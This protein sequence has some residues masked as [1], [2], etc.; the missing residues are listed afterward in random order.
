MNYKVLF[1]SALFITWTSYLSAQGINELDLELNK[2]APDCINAKKLLIAT[3]SDSTRLQSYVSSITESLANLEALQQNLDAGCD[4]LLASYKQGSFLETASS[5]FSTINTLQEKLKASL[6]HSGL[7]IDM[8]KKFSIMMEMLNEISAD[9]MQTTTDS[10]SLMCDEGRAKVLAFSQNINDVLMSIKQNYLE[11]FIPNR[12]ETINK[13]LEKCP[14]TQ[15]GLITKTYLNTGNEFEKRIPRARFEDYKITFDKPFAEV[16]S[17]AVSLAG[18]DMDTELPAVVALVQK[19]TETDFTLRIHVV[20]YARLYS[21]Q[22]SYLATLPSSSGIMPILHMVDASHD[23]DLREISE[24]V[25][26]RSLERKVPLPEEF[27]NSEV[28]VVT[29]LNGFS[30][31]EGADPRVKVSVTNVSPTDFTLRYSTAGSTRFLSAVT[32]NLVYK[33]SEKIYSNSNEATPMKTGKIYTGFG[34]R[35]EMAKSLSLGSFKTQPEM[36]VGLFAFDFT[37]GYNYRISQALK[38][39]DKDKKSTAE[40]SF[41][42]SGDSKVNLVKSSIFYTCYNRLC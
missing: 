16:P 37:S 14:I 31:G 22:V 4:N 7:S 15:T 42:T 19:A 34:N 25:G 28:G 5:T 11:S 9:K 27:K 8:R 35:D 10:A 41:L 29:F 2:E 18:F 30:F 24:I 36:F 26:P 1:L 13:V 39:E 20:P 21:I 3:E 23:K 40:L 32:Y 12:R 33:T 17:L 6:G 38:V